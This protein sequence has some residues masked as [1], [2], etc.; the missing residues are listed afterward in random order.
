MSQDPIVAGAGSQPEV[1][2]DE[3]IELQSRLSFQEDTINEL[4]NIVARQDRQLQALTKQLSSLARKF[5][6]ATFDRDQGGSTA[7]ERPPHY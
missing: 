3:L 4:S 6:E 1:S 7:D 2:Q 5:D